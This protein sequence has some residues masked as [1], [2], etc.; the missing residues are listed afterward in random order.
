MVTLVRVTPELRDV[1]LDPLQRKALVPETLVACLRPL[2]SELGVGEEPEDAE[3][4]VQGHDDHA[5][6]REGRAFVKVPAAIRKGDR[7]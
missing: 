6:A 4:V 5:V 7:V 3:A 2:R 1:G